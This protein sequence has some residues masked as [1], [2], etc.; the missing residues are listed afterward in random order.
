[1]SYSAKDGAVAL[2]AVLA[3]ALP[4]PAFA[5]VAAQWNMDNTFGTTMVDSSGNGNNGT[6]YNVVTS[7]GGYIFDGSTSYVVVPNAPSLNPGSSDFSYSAQVQTDRIPPSGTDYDILRH[8][9]SSTIGGGYRLEIERS[10][11][12]AVAYCSVSDSSGVTA[13]IRG[14]TNVADGNLHTLTCSKTST[15][16]TLQV[17][18]LAPLVKAAT[19]GSVGN[20][21]PFLIGVKALNV[22][23]VDADWYFRT[24]RSATVSVGP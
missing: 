3:L 17:D 11:G 16:I 24:I 5:S 13:S 4:T 19:L 8:G 14:T 15:G 12:R 9:A 10:N 23:G 21:K 20:A 1:M 18:A 2:A 22:S 6:M 7:G